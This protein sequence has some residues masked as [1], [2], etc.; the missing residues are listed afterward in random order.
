MRDIK[1]Y[2]EKYLD[3]GFERYQIYYRRKLILE[4]I[5]KYS[6]KKILEIG[7]GMDPLFQYIDPKYLVYTVVEPSTEFYKNAVNLSKQF[8]NV[9]IFN[10]EFSPREEYDLNKYDFMNLI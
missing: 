7:C 2:T 8:S 6:P 1:D 5:E 10:E 9:C 3:L 4:F